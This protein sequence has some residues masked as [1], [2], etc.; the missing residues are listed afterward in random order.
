MSTTPQLT[1]T[2]TLQDQTGTPIPKAQ[3]VIALCGYGP[4]L[5]RIIGTSMLA[6]VGP[7]EYTLTDGTTTAWTTA[8][9]TSGGPAIPLWGNDVITPAGTYYSVAVVDQKK[10]VVQCGIYEFTGAGS[11]DLSTAQPIDPTPGGGAVTPPLQYTT[12]DYWGISSTVNT[13]QPATLEQIATALGLNV[14][15]PIPAMPLR[16]RTML[17]PPGYLYTLTRSAYNN[18]LIGLFYNGNLLIP[19][20]N[21]SLTQRTIGLGFWTQSGD[22]LYAIYVATSLS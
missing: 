22:N 10:N 3:L 21:Y 1:L 12:S 5:P 19:S 15:H 2:A 16:T 7:V 4:T 13:Q 20:F 8:D 6:K 9:G 11:I 18:T 14:N 17:A